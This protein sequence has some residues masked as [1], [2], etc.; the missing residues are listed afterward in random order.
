MYF[1]EVIK[2]NHKT[3][4]HIT[5]YEI[6]VTVKV[7]RSNLIIVILKERKGFHALVLVHSFWNVLKLLDGNAAMLII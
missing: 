2:T 3:I 4:K 7:T 6:Y 1:R 5:V